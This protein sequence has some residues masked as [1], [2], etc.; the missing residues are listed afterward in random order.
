MDSDN[1]DTKINKPGS[2]DTWNVAIRFG[3]RVRVVSGALEG[4]CGTVVGQR[5]SGRI[6]VK[7]REGVLLEIDAFCLQILGK[8]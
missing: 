2:G 6:V 1:E 8:S 3:Q 4:L 5:A 7:I